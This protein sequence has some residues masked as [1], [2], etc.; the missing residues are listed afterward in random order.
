MNIT[1]KLFTWVISKETGFFKIFLLP[2]IT[3][4]SSIEYWLPTFTT[5]LMSV[6][7]VKCSEHRYLESL[8][9]RE[10]YHSLMTRIVTKID[11]LN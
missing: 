7:L 2:I 4:Q 6:S 3:Y 1:I 8:C 10:L 11:I 9:T 5:M